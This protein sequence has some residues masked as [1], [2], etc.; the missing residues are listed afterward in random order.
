M[1]NFSAIPK[2]VQSNSVLGLTE[3]PFAYKTVCQRCQTNDEGISS[4]TLVNILTILKDLICLNNISYYSIHQNFS[5]RVKVRILIFGGS[6]NIS[7]S[8]L[9]KIKKLKCFFVEG[10]LSSDGRPVHPAF[11]TGATAFHDLI[12][13]SEH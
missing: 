5:Q 8:Q 13:V 1:D 11:Y 3:V 7:L 4:S 9:N 10:T 6:L 12:Y 2:F